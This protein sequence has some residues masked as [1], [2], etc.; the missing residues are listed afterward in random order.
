MN[1]PHGNENLNLQVIMILT[2][3]ENFQLVEEAEFRLAQLLEVKAEQT[4]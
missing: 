2:S 3:A 4:K 1:N